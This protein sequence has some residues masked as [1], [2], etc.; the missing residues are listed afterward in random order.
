L[1]FCLDD[2]AKLQSATPPPQDEPQATLMITPEVLRTMQAGA[3]NTSPTP[4]PQQTYSPPPQTFSPPPTQYSQAGAGWSATPAAPAPP[5]KSAMPWI[6]GGV[7]VLLLGGIAVVVVVLVLA[8][9]NANNNNNNNQNSNNNNNRAAASPTPTPTPAA[10]T[11]VLASTDGVS[12]ISVPDDWQSATDLNTSAKIQAKNPSQTMFA[13][14]ITDPSSASDS[15]ESYA[16]GRYN[17]LK[18]SLTGIRES[19]PVTATINGADSKVY[20]IHGKI[21]N[22]VYI[23]YVFAIVKTADH[24]HQIYA[25]TGENTFTANRA[26]LQSVIESFRE[27]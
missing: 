3:Q 15:L 7:V 12:T 27:E 26:T 20:E 1:S 5:K 21:G 13:I 16:E 9:M 24:Y 23:G 19:G 2:G 18:G 17:T 10:T 11:K 25:W 6:I 8:S 22:G 4:P 14:V